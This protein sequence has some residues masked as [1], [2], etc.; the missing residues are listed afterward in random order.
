M[1]RRMDLLNQI[2]RQLSVL[3]TE[4]ALENRSNRMTLNSD[5]ESIY[6][7]FI[8][9]L[10]GWELG[11]LNEEAQNFPGIDLADRKR[12]I[13]V[14][15]TASA[16]AEKLRHTLKTFFKYGQDRQFKRLILLITTDRP[17]PGGN[18]KLERPFDFRPERDIWNLE[19]MKRKVEAI[20]DA[21]HLQL[22]ADYLDSQLGLLPGVRKPEHLL[23]PVPAACVG[24][25]KGSRDG[26][27]EILEQAVRTGRPVFLWGLGGMGK[28]QTAIQLANR[29]AGERGA[30]F[31][32]YAGSMR[33][34]VRTAN[35]CG[36]CLNAGGKTDPEALI[37]QEYREKLEILRREYGDTILVIDNFNIDGVSLEE[38]KAEPACR[39]VLALENLGVRLIFTTRCDPGVPEWEIGPMAEER[40]VELMR[41]YCTD[42]SVGEADMRALIQA[43]GGHTL[44]VELIAK[45][46]EESW[47]A[48]TAEQVLEALAHA[49]LDR[50]DFPDVASDKDGQLRQVQIY[51]H[52]MAL[53]NLSGL[54]DGARRVLSLSSLAAAEGLDDLIFRGALVGP[55]AKELR[56]L[57]KRGWL[58]RTDRVIIIHPAICQVVRGELIPGEAQVRAFLD[59]LWALLQGKQYAGGT[60]RR[61]AMCM[62]AGADYIDDPDVYFDVKKHTLTLW[63]Q[64]LP[65]DSAEMAQ[66]YSDMG[67]V[68]IEMGDYEGALQYKSRALGIKQ[69]ALPPDDP[70]IEMARE[71]LEA[72]ENAKKEAGE[73]CQ[74]VITDEEGGKFYLDEED[75][76]RMNELVAVHSKIEELSVELNQYLKKF[77]D[78]HLEGRREIQEW[79]SPEGL[80]MFE[81]FGIE[82]D[83][84]LLDELDMETNLVLQLIA[85]NEEDGDHEQQKNCTERL[86]EM[87]DRV[88]AKVDRIVE[89][90]AEC[91]EA[92]E[93]QPWTE[94]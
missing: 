77:I 65:G 9:R 55:D 62:G 16:T 47:N 92:M 71:L 20:E 33:E 88:D 34:T 10:C 72:V 29:C 86:L 82:L 66:V 41:K 1:A 68:Y 8:N 75:F 37:E 94:A 57:V 43:V 40:L 91:M 22:L 85:L 61:A 3:A 24:F 87:M 80:K 49:E 81:A 48:V 58:Q 89:Q 39:D 28:S 4:I 19:A 31:L 74:V 14:Q 90:I 26:E 46:L 73:D 44:M 67:G 35:I 83:Q 84:E 2:T 42:A 79:F 51:Q 69:Y 64:I 23:P 59:R 21:E 53:F 78:R 76:S 17:A 30:Y 38:L 50:D 7:G 6:C 18:C 13:A 11:N 15:I 27:L 54:S 52:I 45:T 36:Y 12:G 25:L 32:R 93:D 60:L 70:V 5:V 56:N 63:E